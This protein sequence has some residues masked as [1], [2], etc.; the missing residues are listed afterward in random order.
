MLNLSYLFVFPFYGLGAILLHYLILFFFFVPSFCIRFDRD[1]KKIEAFVGSK[2]VIQIRSHAQKYFLK[3]QKSGTNEHLPPPRPKRKAAHPYPQKASKTAP[4]LSQVSG[5][6]QSSSALLEPGYILKHDSSA[7][8]KTPIINTAVSSWSNN[9]LQKT[10]SVLHG[11]KQKVNNCCSSSR[12][13][14]AQLVGESNG[15][16]NNSHPLRVLPDFAEVYSFI[17]SVFDPN[18][19]GHVQKLKRMDPIDVETVLLL[20][21]NL[22]INLAS[23]DFEDHRRLLASYEVE[24]EVDKYKC[25]LNHA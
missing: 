2:T 25:R 4:V 20:M 6:F 10:T 16:R 14:R 11:Q 23:P 8:P 7:M 19:T 9:S 15:Q 12:S 5:S 17:G 18:V 22:S 1:W 21:R 24:P 3:V 13:P